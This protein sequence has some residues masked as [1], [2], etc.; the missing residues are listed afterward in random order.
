MTRLP[1]IIEDLASAIA[2]ITPR[3]EPIIISLRPE[4]YRAV[5]RE[6]GDHFGEMLTVD[7]SRLGQQDKS[8]ELGGV[9]IRAA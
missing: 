3:P 1:F 5:S 8:I 2:A 6:L 7:M 4:S 9:T